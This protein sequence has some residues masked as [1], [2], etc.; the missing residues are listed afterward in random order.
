MVVR[1]SAL[2]TTLPYG[3]YCLMQYC[4]EKGSVGRRED[5]V[6]DLKKDT[7]ENVRKLI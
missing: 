6:N 4:V 1:L 5:E 7:E 3:N 2:R